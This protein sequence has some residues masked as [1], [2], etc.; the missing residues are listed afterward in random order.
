M[1]IL[2]VSGAPWEVTL[3]PRDHPGGPWEQQDGREVANNRIFFDFG[4]ILEPVYGSFGE[5][6]CLFFFVCAW[7]QVILLPISA[8]KFR[9]LGLSNR[10]FRMEGIATIGFS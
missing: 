8:S 3:P 5:P 4:V 6:K 7:F 1:A 9:R 2:G 10:G